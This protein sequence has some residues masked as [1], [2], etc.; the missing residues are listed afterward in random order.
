MA[1]TIEDLTVGTGAEVADDKLITVSYTV[2][3]A[4][5]TLVIGQLQPNETVEVPVGGQMLIQGWNDG[6]VGMKVG[7]KRRISVPPELA[8]TNVGLGDIVPIE[9]TLIFEVNLISIRDIPS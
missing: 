9:A 4:P 6:M 1:V 3:I 7:G 5:D 8:Y 2:K